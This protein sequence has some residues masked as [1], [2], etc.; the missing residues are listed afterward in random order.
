LAKRWLVNAAPAADGSIDTALIANTELLEKGYFPIAGTSTRTEYAYIIS[1][2]VGAKV[3]ERLHRIASESSI[4]MKMAGRASL[5]IVRAITGRKRDEFRLVVLDY[6]GGDLIVDPFPQ[7]V[8]DNLATS[9]GLVYFFDATSAENIDYLGRPIEILWA[10]MYARG[11]LLDGLLPHYL[12]VC[13]TKY[14]DPANFDRLVDEELVTEALEGVPCVPE[15]AE[16]DAFDML[17]TI[18]LPDGRTNER[19]G[20]IIDTYF[21]P[22]RVRF[23]LTSNIG[24]YRRNPNDPIDPNDCSNTWIVGNDTRIRGRVEPINVLDPL[25]WIYDQARANPRQKPRP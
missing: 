23:Y 5:K 25:V 18:E 13:I 10:Y 9:D 6:P 19:I 24:F 7:E 15:G 12:A 17:S 20:Q 4:F 1:K 8:R 11:E 22:E 16:R 2:M 3:T 14:D 21:A